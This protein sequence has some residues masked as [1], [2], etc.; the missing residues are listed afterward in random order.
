M[1]ETWPDPI[2]TAIGSTLLRFNH[3]EVALRNMLIRLLS[4]DREAAALVVFGNTSFAWLHGQL[5]V[6]ARRKITDPRLAADWQA[7]L[8]EVGLLQKE[9]NRL[10]HDLW[11]WHSA[12]TLMRIQYRVRAGEVRLENDELPHDHINWIAIRASD[13][14]GQF[15]RLQHRLDQ[16]GVLYPL[17]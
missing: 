13:L 8:D 14:I 9:R 17:F 10:A 11:Q 2:E 5:E 1:P 15:N 4:P 16:A 6:Q 3:L 7:F 12:T